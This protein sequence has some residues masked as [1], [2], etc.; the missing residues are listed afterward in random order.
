MNPTQKMES[1]Q[2]CHLIRFLP[3][4]QFLSTDGDLTQCI[5]VCDVRLEETALG[6]DIIG[7]F[8]AF[9]IQCDLIERVG[10]EVDA[11]RIAFG[12]CSVFHEMPPAN[13]QQLYRYKKVTVTFNATIT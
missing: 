2:F 9:A 6:A 11:G 3:I 7:V 13:F 10:F 1:L 8:N 12:T 4:A 5:P